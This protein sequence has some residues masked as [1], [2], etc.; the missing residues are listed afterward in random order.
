M[1]KKHTQSK[2]SCMKTQEEIGEIHL[3]AKEWQG[4]LKL[5]GG[6]EGKGSPLQASEGTRPC[7]FLDFRHLASDM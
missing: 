4:L 6:T 5:G 3:Q 2:D 7:Q 1:Q